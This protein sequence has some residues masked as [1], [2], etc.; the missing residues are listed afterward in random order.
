MSASPS[1]YPGLTFKVADPGE[2]ERALALRREIYG[3]EH[4]RIPDDEPDAVHFVARTDAGEVVGAFRLLP[5]ETRPFEF[6]PMVDVRTLLLPG[7]R[8]AHIGRLCVRE[9]HRVVRRG[10]FLHLGLMTIT[11]AYAEKHAITDLVLYTFESLTAF[12]R[13]A[14]FRDARLPFEH[15]EWGPQVLMHLDVGDLAARCA[16]STSPTARLLASRDV[17]WL[18]L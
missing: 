3:R 18:L 11:L 8:P 10:M 9:D 16:E 6:E 4:G 14:F 1:P 12:Y 7:R 17:P 2:R 15:P 13:V 5:P